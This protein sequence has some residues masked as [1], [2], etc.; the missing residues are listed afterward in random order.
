MSDEPVVARVIEPLTKPPARDGGRPGVEEHHEP[1]AA[2]GRRCPRVVDH[3][4]CAR[5]GRHRGHG[6]RPAGAGGHRRSGGW[7]VAGDARCVGARRVDLRGRH[8]ALGDDLP[9]PAAG[10][11]MRTA[12][13]APGRPPPI[14][15]PSDGAAATGAG[16]PGRSGRGVGLPGLPAGGDRRAAAARRPRHGRREHLQPVPLRAPVEPRRAWTEGWRSRSRARLWP[17][18]S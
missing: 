4:R 12:T 18:R 17:D 2:P 14:A 16:R 7:C 5:C 3:H 6:R 13:G 15:C 10:G 1:R 8:A 9:V 11:R